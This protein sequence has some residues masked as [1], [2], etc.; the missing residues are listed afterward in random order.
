VPS[1]IPDSVVVAVDG[2]DEIPRTL[3][4]LLSTFVFARAEGD[5]P[6]DPFA[7]PAFPADEPRVGV[8]P[9]SPHEPLRSAA[10][11]GPAEAS[12]RKHAEPDG[13]P[14]PPFPSELFAE[15][16]SEADDG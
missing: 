5:V 16:S 2:R 3:A 4:A 1:N 8:A 10:G 6:A 12:A 15:K 13:A 14:D 9:V 11:D 7:L